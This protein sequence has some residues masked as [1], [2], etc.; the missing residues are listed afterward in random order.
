M[1]MI[2]K[3]PDYGVDG[4]PIRGQCQPNVFGWQLRYIS[5]GEETLLCESDY[6]ICREAQERCK[7][8]PLELAKLRAKQIASTKTIDM[9]DTTQ[10]T[11]NR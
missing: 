5:N 11:I 9:E 8:L 7:N 2:G 3:P 1:L 4:I 10:F 6:Y